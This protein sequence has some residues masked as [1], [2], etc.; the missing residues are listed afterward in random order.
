MLGLLDV[1]LGQS[2]TSGQKVG[3]INDLSSFKIEAQINEH[4]IDRVSAGL[5]AS[6]ER[7]DCRTGQLPG[8][9]VVLDSDKG[10]VDVP[11]ILSHLH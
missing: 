1:V 11:Y 10:L 6:F 5:A 3:Q 2:I 7:Q 4:Y 8:V 9:D